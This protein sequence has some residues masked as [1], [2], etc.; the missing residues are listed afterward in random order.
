MGSHMPLHPFRGADANVQNSTYVFVSPSPT[1]KPLGVVR[2][3][4][5]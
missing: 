1:L 3:L 5:L 4:V 2:A